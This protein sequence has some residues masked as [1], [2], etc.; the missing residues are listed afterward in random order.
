MIAARTGN[1][2]F[3]ALLIY[4][5]K[6]AL[7]SDWILADISSASPT[8][9][10]S[11]MNEMMNQYV[12]G[13]AAGIFKEIHIPIVTVNSDLW[14]IN[15]EANQRHMGSFEAIVLKDADH[16]LLLRRPAAFNPALAK[17]I[18]VLSEKPGE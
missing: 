6:D 9:A 7:L 15:F 1:R 14:S 10:L 4:P 18:R 12:T 16:F 17:A 11:A 5:D 8:V 3:V 13:E 2:Q